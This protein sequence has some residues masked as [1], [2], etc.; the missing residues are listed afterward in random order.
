MSIDLE[1]ELK[2]MA[3][4][5]GLTEKQVL[6]WWRSSVRQMWANSPF[7]R[8]M[9]E[10]HQFE[11]VNDNPRS[12]KRYPVVKR[13]KCN[14][15]NDI[16]SPSAMELDHIIGENKAESLSDA[17]S[18]MRAILFTPKDN[19]QWLC[20]DGKKTVNKKRVT[21]SIGCHSSKTQLESNPSLS[22]H[23][24]WVIREVKRIV[25][26]ENLLDKC[27]E[28]GVESSNVPKTKK[29]REALVYKLLLEGGISE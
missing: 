23:E 18:F 5:Y 1:K 6:N 2:F 12:M 15:C 25:K 21:S 16:F 8:H 28:L 29:A 3:T 10:T 19:L 24:A 26:Y 17:E 14:K 27:I 9:E 22:E 4:E 13:M 7:K 20:A 11:V